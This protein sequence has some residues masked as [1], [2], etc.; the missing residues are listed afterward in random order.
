VVPATVTPRREEAAVMENDPLL[1]DDV[2]DYPD[3]EDEDAIL[4]QADGDD[5]DDSWDEEDEDEE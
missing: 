4:E 3:E 1:G 2:D 5:E